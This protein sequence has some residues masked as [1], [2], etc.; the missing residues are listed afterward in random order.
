MEKKCEGYTLFLILTACDEWDWIEGRRGLAFLYT[1]YCLN[2]HDGHVKFL[3]F[4]NRVEKIKIETWILN[5]LLF[6]LGF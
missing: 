4:E 1:S 6:H 2:Q 3:E 5:N